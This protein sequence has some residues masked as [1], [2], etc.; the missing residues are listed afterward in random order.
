MS[1][2]AL[3]YLQ[4]MV[5][6]LAHSPEFESIELFASSLVQQSLSKSVD[7]HVESW[8]AMDGWT[9]FR[10]LKGKLKKSAPDVVF[11]PYGRWLN[12][13]NAATVVMIRNMEPLVKLRVVNPWRERLKNVA[14]EFEARRACQRATRILAVSQFVYEH[15]SVQWRISPEKMAR[16]Y[17]GIDTAG[18]APR[19]PAALSGLKDR[20]LFTAGS[21]RPYRG[22]EDAIGAVIA[23][24]KKGQKSILVIAGQSDS[25]ME[26]YKDAL[27]QTAAQ[28]SC[29]N[30]IIWTGN[31]PAHE[32][33][34]CYQNCEAFIMSSR[35]EACPNTALEAMN[36]KCVIISTRNPPMPEFFQNCAIFYDAGDAE[37]L[38]KAL[39]ETAS[40]STHER[41]RLK[42]ATYQRATAFSWQECARQ[43]VEQL[44]L[45]VRAESC[46][47]FMR[48]AQN[49]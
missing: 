38:V 24:R 15:L 33:A 27:L 49:I 7:M 40:L 10:E 32:L 37:G 25:G 3:K 42:A 46:S 31:L 17:H 36:E 39:N 20:F 13:G 29:E 45:A 35:V 12:C 2:G 11:I 26:F 19:Q 14:R 23:L 5:P 44:K 1:G 9:G 34:W 18:E 30:A 4:K 22:L 41:A 8:P 48:P 21:I 47:S 6:R 16:V 43:T 28:A